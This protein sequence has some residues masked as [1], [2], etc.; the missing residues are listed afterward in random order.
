MY[1]FPSS[2]DFSLHEIYSEHSNLTHSHSGF[3]LA[4]ITF[5]IVQIT[6][7]SHLASAST[8]GPDFSTSTVISDLVQF[9]PGVTI[10]LTSFLVFGTTKRFFP[11]YKS[12]L[13]C[14]SPSRAAKSA[15]HGRRSRWPVIKHLGTVT[16]S[17]ED[18]QGPENEKKSGDYVRNFS[19]P[20]P[21][22]LTLKEKRS[23]VSEKSSESESAA[24]SLKSENAPDLNKPLP[25]TPS[26]KCITI[27][28][29]VRKSTWDVRENEVDD[30]D[31]CDQ[32][33]MSGHRK[34]EE[35]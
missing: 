5:N 28:L 15:R 35:A 27:G 24:G 32:H 30:C 17:E 14:R 18:V 10:S 7:T 6:H 9:I 21:L 19:R 1:V 23:P 4:A 22:D 33:R 20:I 8:T 13:M 34:D 26:A 12:L 25:H 16:S 2:H 31:D 3:E 11:I 29:V